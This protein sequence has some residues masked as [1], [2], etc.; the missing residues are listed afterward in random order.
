MSL[1]LI[2]LFLVCFCATLVR[3][4]FGF[5][6]SLIAVP[7]FSIFMPIG[8]AV[9]LSVLISVLVALV[10]VVQDYRQIHLHSAKWLILSALPGIPVGLVILIYGDQ[11]WVKT[12]LGLLVILYSLYALFG[13]GA[14]RLEKDSKVWLI[15][16]GCLSGVLGGAYGIN[17]PPLVVYG[18]MR[19]WSAKE[20][21]ATLQGYFLPA[22]LAGILG[23]SLKGLIT[24]QVG[25]YFLLSLPA[26]LP[27]IFL[28]RYLNH[29]LKDGTFFK[30]VYAG[31]FLIGLLLIV[32]SILGV[33]S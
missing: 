23:Y 28:G 1:I 33:Q 4:T 20:F 14:L 29:Q 26:V 27:A 2:Y 5:G 7:L 19:R 18:N 9:P 3:S 25:K 22:S 15:V 32:F 16:C 11:L 30:Y 8:L 17:G 24:L 21:R 6:E 13:A 31:L 10:V 12:G